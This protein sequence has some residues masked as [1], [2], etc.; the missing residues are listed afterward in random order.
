[1]RPNLRTH[2]LCQVQR[3]HSV[4]ALWLPP[5]IGIANINSLGIHPDQLGHRHRELPSDG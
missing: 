3:L 2:L 1:M 5:V 4:F